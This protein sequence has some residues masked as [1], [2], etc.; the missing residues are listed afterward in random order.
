MTSQFQDVVTSVENFIKVLG[1][2]AGMYFAFKIIISYQKD[3]LGSLQKAN[4]DLRDEIRE[5]DERIELLE[6]RLDQVRSDLR[7][8]RE[9]CDA[10]IAQLRTAMRDSGIPVPPPPTY[11]TRD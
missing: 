10:T 9:W 11:P 3:L 2:F 6:K 7:K 5:Q 4:I 8:E 1:P